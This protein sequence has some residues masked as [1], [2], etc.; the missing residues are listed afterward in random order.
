[1]SH[2]A[3]C[4][5]EILDLETLREA[6][7]YMGGEYLPNKTKWRW[8]PSGWQ[9]DYSAKNAAYLN[10]ITVDRYG[11]S[12]AGIIRFDG[13][14]YDVGVYKVPG[15]PGK[16]CLVYDNFNQGSGLEKKCGKDLVDLRT[17]Y[18][19]VAATK[20]LKKQG[21]TVKEERNPATNRLRLVATRRKF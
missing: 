15:Q 9:N 3:K 21:F 4:E 12:D 16:F 17:R 18:G 5:L 20:Q 10:G 7:E 2:V 19:A 1:M 8:Y 6:V 11:K 14:G 13:C